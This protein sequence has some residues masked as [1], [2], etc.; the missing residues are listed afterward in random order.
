MK[1]KSKSWIKLFELILFKIN[2]SFITIFLFLFSL[3]F[4]LISSL[5]LFSLNLSNDIFF[6]YFQYYFII[7]YNILLFIFVVMNA[8]KI[9]GIPIEDNSF[10][11][12]ITKP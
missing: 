2:H 5:I 10:L 1:N 6:G 4:S 12:L 3:L 8:I 9:F 7:F 11:L